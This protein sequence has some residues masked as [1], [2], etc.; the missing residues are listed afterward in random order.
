MLRAIAAHTAPFIQRVPEISKVRAGFILT[1]LFAET[2]I[3]YQ[4]IIISKEQEILWL[5]Y[6]K[7]CQIG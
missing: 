5:R 6:C 3:R 7:S 4:K 2:I 1:Y